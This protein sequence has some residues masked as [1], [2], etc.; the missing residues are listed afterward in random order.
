MTPLLVLLFGVHPATAVG[1][2]LLYAAMTKPAARGARPQGHI[3]W[4]ITGRLAAGSI[5]AAAITIWVLS[6]T[7]Q[8]EQHH[9]RHHRPRPRFR[10]LLLTAI[11]PSLRRKIRA[12]PQKHE[13]S[14]LRQCCLNKITVAVG[15]CSACWSPISVGAGALGVAAVLPLSQTV[16]GSHRRLR[17]GATPCLLTLVA[18]LGHWLLGSVDWRCSA[19]CCSVRCPASGSAATFRQGPRTHPAPHPGLMLVLIGSKLVFA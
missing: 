2:D 9:R 14:P 7:A 18:G 6:P 11:A 3:D 13:D 12:T 16:V 4:A 8:R 15:A 5:P 19:A 17:R 1:T 10:L